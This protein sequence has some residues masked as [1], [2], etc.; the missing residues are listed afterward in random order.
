[1]E[2]GVIAKMRR[3]RYA[4]HLTVSNCLCSV[5]QSAAKLGSNNEF[6]DGD[7]PRTLPNFYYSAYSIIHAPQNGLHFYSSFHVAL[8]HPNSLQNRR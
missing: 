2:L 3:L 5:S 8:F 6:V 7:T 1:M 4:F